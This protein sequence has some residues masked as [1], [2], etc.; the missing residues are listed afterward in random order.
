MNQYF[1][2]DEFIKSNV[3]LERGIDNT[4]SED[5]KK[6]LSLTMASMEVIRLFLGNPII[7][8]SGYR[9]PNLNKWVGGSLKSQHMRGQACD[10]TCPLLGPPIEVAKMLSAKVIE[11]GIDQMIM[12][13]TWVHVSFTTTPRNQVLTM[14]DG[15]YYEGILET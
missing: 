14:R 3:A 4:P 2:L 8:H 9:S 5:I 11:F 12:E 6:Q 10:F 15:K 1:T 13:G 7:I